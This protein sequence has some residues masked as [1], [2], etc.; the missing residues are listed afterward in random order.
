LAIFCFQRCRG[1]ESFRLSGLL[2]DT[3]LTRA[4]G[5]G[6]EPKFSLSESDVLPLDDPA[7][8]AQL[9]QNT[10]KHRHIQGLT[11]LIMIVVCGGI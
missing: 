5:L 10:L 7:I 2:L 3:T 11:K 9:I 8:W 4:A 6:I 1:L